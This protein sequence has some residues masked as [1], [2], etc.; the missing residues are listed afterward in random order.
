M[1]RALNTGF[2]RL[3]SWAECF[4]DQGTFTDVGGATGL[5]NGYA[6]PSGY[7][8][9]S[10]VDRDKWD[11]RYREGAYAERGHPAAFLVEHVPEILAQQLNAKTSNESLRALDIACGAGRNSFYLA[12]LGYQVD[13]VDVSAEA[14]NRA[15]ATG[16]DHHA[17]ICWVEQDLDNGLP[18]DLPP[19]DMMAIIR[20]LDLD[21][22]RAAL[23]HI[24]PGGYLLCEVHLATEQVVAGPSGSAFRAAPG[25]LL[26]AASG[27]EIISYWEGVTRDPDQA[28]VA[29]AR[30]VGRL[31]P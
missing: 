22:V 15:R 12:G 27:L 8:S 24:R 4:Y 2:D 13:A 11:Q 28:L 3:Y 17:S 25:A 23:R 20:Y 16:N 29:V 9:V 31:P 19:A 14:L 6:I 5:L 21:M 7:I 30:L 18:A 1:Q 10:Q 26:D